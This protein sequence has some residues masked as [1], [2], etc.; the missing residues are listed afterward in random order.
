MKTVTPEMQRDM[1]REMQRVGGFV[2]V[3]QG[4]FI[5]L[6]ACKDFRFEAAFLYAGFLVND[7]RWDW[8]AL[9]AAVAKVFRKIQLLSE[10][11]GEI[12]RRIAR[13][14]NGDLYDRGA[15]IGDLSRTW[16]DEQK[17]LI[18][19]LHALEKKGVLKVSEGAW[20]VVR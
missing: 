11:E 5:D 16:P 1:Q 9:A 15:H 8:V 17:E 20:K 18:G 3:N 13:A 7:Y 12:I 10:D 2:I 19:R 6:E 4:I 14:S